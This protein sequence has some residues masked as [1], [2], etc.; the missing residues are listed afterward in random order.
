MS[1]FLI[2]SVIFARENPLAFQKPQILCGSNHQ[3][4]FCRDFALLDGVKRQNDGTG[5]S[6]ADRTINLDRSPH[7]FAPLFDDGKT[8]ARAMGFRKIHSILLS[9]RLKEM[10]LEF[11]AHPDAIILNFVSDLDPRR[12]D[13]S[14]KNRIGDA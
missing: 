1:H 10:L 4:W 2:E 11:F 3:A 5:A 9:E 14:T 12:A 6:L 8:Q 7:C 13:Q